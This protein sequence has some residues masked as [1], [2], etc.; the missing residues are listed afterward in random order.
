MIHEAIKP[1]QKKIKQQLKRLIADIE[2][3][4]EAYYDTID[5]LE[6]ENKTTQAENYSEKLDMLQNLK[7]D[8]ETYLEIT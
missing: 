7:M 3:L 4:E 5:V 1:T 6:D 8:I 2:T